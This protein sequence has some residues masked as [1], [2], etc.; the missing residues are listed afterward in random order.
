MDTP[1]PKYEVQYSIPDKLSRNKAP[2]D[3]SPKPLAKFTV[4]CHTAH[5]ATLLF[6]TS[7]N[8]GK[9]YCKMLAQRMW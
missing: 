3:R 1:T 4:H 7:A 9:Y 8:S 5:A 6:Q 2:H